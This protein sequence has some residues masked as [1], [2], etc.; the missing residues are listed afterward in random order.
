MIKKLNDDNFI[1]FAIKAYNNPECESDKEFYNDLKR[2][3]YIKKLLNKYLLTGD[4][5]TRLILNHITVLQNV[6]GVRATTR[7]LFYKLSKEFHPALKTFLTYKYAIPVKDFDNI[8]I[9]RIPLDLKIINI[10]RE[11]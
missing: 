11:L 2:I 6:F 1:L 10:L 7:M 5:K 3:N 8:K 4:L 9:N